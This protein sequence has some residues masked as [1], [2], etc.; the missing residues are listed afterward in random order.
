MVKRR[1]KVFKETDGLEVVFNSDDA[2]V[3]DVG[4]GGYVVTYKG[5]GTQ[6]LVRLSGQSARSRAMAIAIATAAPCAPCNESKIQ[7]VAVKPPSALETAETNLPATEPTGDDE[8][9]SRE[10]EGV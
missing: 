9:I 10:T 2:S 3:T 5:T 6:D 7:R 4:D 1:L 8:T